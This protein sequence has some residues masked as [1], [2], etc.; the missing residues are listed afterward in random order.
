MKTLYL[1]RHAKS[2]WDDLSMNDLDRPLNTRGKKDAPH[3]GKLLANMNIKPDLLLSSPAKRAKTTAFAMAEPLG[4]AKTEVQ[5][6][7]DLYH[8]SAGELIKVISAV[9]DSVNS[10]MLF[11]HNPGLTFL[12]NRFSPGIIDNIPTTGVV[13]FEFYT[14]KWADMEDAD[15][16]L[17]FFEFPK[18][19]L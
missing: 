12:A 13:C 14:F 7:D 3:M 4:K 9:D 8:A 6:N 16:Q 17:K 18:K 2:S 15:A 11:G 5:L 19:S 10:L 1:V